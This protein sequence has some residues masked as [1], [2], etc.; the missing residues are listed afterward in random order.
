MAASPNTPPNI[1]LSSTVVF[2]TRGGGS[3]PSIQC[4]PIVYQ[5]SACRRTRSQD[6]THRPQRQ[7]HPTRHSPHRAKF[8][9]IRTS[10]TT[11][12]TGHDA[13]RERETSYPSVKQTCTTYTCTPSNFIYHII[14]SQRVLIQFENTRFIPHIHFVILSSF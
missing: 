3:S 11:V 14:E 9:H 2:S 7:A 13:R 10:H 8:H 4:C 5:A 12:P 1:A 6:T